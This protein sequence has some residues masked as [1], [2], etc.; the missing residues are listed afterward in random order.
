MKVF[1]ILVGDSLS[2][3]YLDFSVSIFATRRVVI[4]HV[5]WTK[6]FVRLSVRE[7]VRVITNGHKNEKGENNCT[8]WLKLYTFKVHPK[9]FIF[10]WGSSVTTFLWV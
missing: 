6:K 4:I 2:V 5:I 9:L 7:Y 8:I 1:G 3:R 10:Y